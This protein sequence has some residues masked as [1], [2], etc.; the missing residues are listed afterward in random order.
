[1]SATFQRQ[2]PS[3]SSPPVAYGFGIPEIGWNYVCFVRNSMPLA[4]RAVIM[5]RNYLEVSSDKLMTVW[6]LLP[7]VTDFDC[8]RI[9]TVGAIPK[10]NI[11]WLP[12]CC[13]GT[14]PIPKTNTV[15]GPTA[16]GILTCTVCSTSTLSTKLFINGKKLSITYSTFN[17]L[18]ILVNI[19]GSW[20]WSLQ[21]TSKI[22]NEWF[23]LHPSFAISP[24]LLSQWVYNWIWSH[25]TTLW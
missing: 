7:S 6:D 18:F 2:Q 16:T 17:L 10:Q 12:C 3:T 21:C 4:L 11:K 24:P 25:K 23:V 8:N 9:W 13:D 20:Q 14:Q 5:Q 19:W 15:E 22:F 1:M